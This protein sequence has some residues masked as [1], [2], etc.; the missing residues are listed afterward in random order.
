MFKKIFSFLFLDK[1]IRE[2][3]LFLKKIDV[4]KMF[5]VW[6]LKKITTILFRRTYL[7]N[8]TVYNKN[9]DA[10]LICLLKS[11]KVE[12]DDGQ[13]KKYVLP[14]TKF[15]KRYLLCCDDRYEET[16]KVAEKS[17]IYIIHKEDLETLMNNDTNIG[18][19]ITKILL[20]ILYDR[21]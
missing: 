5:N 4:F 3:I 2:D 6:Q 12:L 14:Y 21:K 9:E 17:E 8:E 7:K 20:E 16:A 18:F 15:G 13:N 10:R 1:E 11:G 19:K